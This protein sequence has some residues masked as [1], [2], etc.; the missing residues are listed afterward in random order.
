MT[1]TT[2]LDPRP[3]PAQVQA[4]L[5]TDLSDGAFHAL[6]AVLTSDP[7]WRLRAIPGPTTWNACLRY[8]PHG[9]SVHVHLVRR[10]PPPPR[11]VSRWQRVHQRL[12]PRPSPPLTTRLTTQRPPPPPAPPPALAPALAPARPTRRYRHGTPAASP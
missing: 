12:R 5:A 2:P 8:S 4:C 11:M 6:L 7:N 9:R 10:T 1:M 3:S